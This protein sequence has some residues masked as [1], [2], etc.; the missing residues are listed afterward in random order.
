MRI[1]SLLLV[2]MSKS[3]LNV[4]TTS[5]TPSRQS[6]NSYTHEEKSNIIRL[7]NNNN[8]SKNKF[9]QELNS[10][11]DTNLS[12]NTFNKWLPKQQHIFDEAELERGRK[13]N[14]FNRKETK[15]PL[16]ELAMVEY[17]IQANSKKGTPDMNWTESKLSSLA[18]SLHAKIES[19]TPTNR[20]KLENSLW[21]GGGFKKEHKLT[22][23]LA[24]LFYKRYPDICIRNAPTE[25]RAKAI[26]RE[27]ASKDTFKSDAVEIKVVSGLGYGLF[28]T[29]PIRKGMRVTGYEGEIITKKFVQ[30]AI[31]HNTAYVWSTGDMKLCIDSQHAYSSFGAYINDSLD[32]NEHIEDSDFNANCKIVRTTRTSTTAEVRA[33]ADI[34]A[35]QQL[36]TAYGKDYWKYDMLAG[37][38]PPRLSLQ[39]EQTYQIEAPAGV[40][41]FTNPNKRYRLK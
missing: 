26:T 10:M 35:G 37:A 7:F 40:S 28:A 39:V 32:P 15:R 27:I 3:K 25:D 11:N 20:T 1:S 41:M 5:D 8:I 19:M 9:L 13:R 36:K 29:K 4:E 2:E 16:L 30:T 22:H 34:P 21:Q 23:N 31:L 17:I 33:I 14:I 38:L 24:Q 18:A 6:R 12:L